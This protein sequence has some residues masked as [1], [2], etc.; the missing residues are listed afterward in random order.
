MVRQGNPN[1]NA[2]EEFVHYSQSSL[3]RNA[4]EIATV[5]GVLQSHSTTHRNVLNPL[6]STV[7]AITAA[8]NADLFK[9]QPLSSS[10]AD[11]AGQGPTLLP[12]PEMS[13]TTT[14][15]RRDRGDATQRAHFGHANQLAATIGG[16]VTLQGQLRAHVEA[17]GTY[18]LPE[19]TNFMYISALWS[20]AADQLLAAEL[21][22]AK[23]QCADF[24]ALR[25]GPQSD[26]RAMLHGAGGATGNLLV[27]SRAFDPDVR[28]CHSRSDCHAGCG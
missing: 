23:L 10:F 2:P 1:V 16:A 4:T 15:A 26:R 28:C 13:T 8:A 22:Y 27:F 18:D 24:D 25:I 5:C 6:A 11:I 12:A 7:S 21:T 20:H 3:H 9:H 14:H 19:R 17:W